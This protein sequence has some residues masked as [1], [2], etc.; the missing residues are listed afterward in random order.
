MRLA[1]T[2][3]KEPSAEILPYR[4][5]KLC[6]E[7]LNLASILPLYRYP[8]ERLRSRV[9]DEDP[10]FFLK[11][12]LGFF[13][14]ISYLRYGGYVPFLP[15]PYVYEH[16]RVYGHFPGEFREILPFPDHYREYLQGRYYPVA[17]CRVV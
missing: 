17:R 7:P 15:H 1:L 13:Q 8:R 2:V 9:A 5:L 12:L 11:S 16:L 6:G 4:L 10:A 3:S 14:D